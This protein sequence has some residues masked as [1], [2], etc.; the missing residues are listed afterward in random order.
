[1]P[2]NANTAPSK[3]VAVVTG[4][5]GGLGAVYADRLAG[6]GYDLIVVAR[7]GGKLDSLAAILGERHGT[8]VETVVADLGNPADL[9]R[10]ASLVAGDAR[11]TMLVNNAGT[12]KLSSIGEAGAAA[13]AAMADVNVKATQRLAQAVMPG[14]KQRDR[15]TIINIGSILGFHSI[16]VSALYSAT[17]SHMLMFTKALQAEVAGTGVIVQLVAP[18]ATATDIWDVAGM[19]LSNLD[20]ATVMTAEHCVD[21][22]L[23]G[24][25]RGERITLPSVENAEALL[26]AYDEAC[27]KLLMASQTSQVASRYRLAG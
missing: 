23:S 16:P 2:Q 7:R 17:K 20:P 9:D 5:S 25:D 18:S 8:I 4:A 1:M 24:L 13:A 12:A 6:R 10:V 26:A 11:I 3:G 21:A 15:G 27:L 19:P 22:A 14:F